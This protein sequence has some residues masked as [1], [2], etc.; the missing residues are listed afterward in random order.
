MFQMVG[1]SKAVA[2]KSSQDSEQEKR[3]IFFFCQHV[4]K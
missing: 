1:D 4:A 3:V 2:P